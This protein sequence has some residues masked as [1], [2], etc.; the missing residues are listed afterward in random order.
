[1]V[2]DEVALLAALK[3]MG[4]ITAR[5][6][7]SVGICSPGKLRAV[8]AAPT[9]LALK[10]RCPGY[11]TALTPYALKG[12]ISGTLA[13]D[14]DVATRGRLK[15]AVAAAHLAGDLETKDG[16]AWK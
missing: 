15:K 10:S 8:G 6:L 3:N 5:R 1:M 7:L 13:R 2:P 11:V 16:F 9:F 12:A 4:S 14:L